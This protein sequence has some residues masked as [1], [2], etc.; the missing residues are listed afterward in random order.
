MPNKDPDILLGRRDSPIVSFLCEHGAATRSE[1]AMAFGLDKKTVARRVDALSLA[2]V[3]VRCGTR[4]SLAGRPHELIGVNGRWANFIG[5][6][7]GATHIIGV[8]TDFSNKV[9]DRV[10][11]EIRPNLP[12]QL[13]LEQMKTIGHN[14][15]ISNKSTGPVRAVGVCVPGFVDIHTGVSVVSENIPGW[16]NIR[17]RDAFRAELGI[18]VSL[19]DSSR[20][21]GLAEK[22]IGLGRNCDHYVLLDLGYGIGMAIISEGRLF[23]GAASRAGE[24]GH[25]VMEP[26]GLPCACGSHGCLETVA[27]GRAIARRAAEGIAAGRSGLLKDLTRDRP[28]S[29]TA[30]DVAI[31][32]SM[33][34]PFARDLLRDAGRFVGIALANVMNILNPSKI[35]L[36]GGLMS[37]EKTMANAI[38]ESLQQHGMRGMIEGVD[39]VVSTLG[40]DGSALG[41][42]I[43]ASD[44]L[45]AAQSKGEHS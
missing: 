43:Q 12:T 45:L 36:G 35:I 29:V 44:F 37:G 32:A 41:A 21:Y 40:V 28:D 11:F 5:L 2:G 4:E 7:L 8:L 17:L 18:P 42:A 31:G 27:S 19:D 13:I 20:A 14:L 38:S 16:K 23:M 6:D 10:F 9:L 24:I 26:S 25:T 34:D 30:Q 3:L 1:I 33:G 15:S 22:R 39:V